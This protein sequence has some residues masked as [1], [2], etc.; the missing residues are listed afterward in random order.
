MYLVYAL[1]QNGMMYAAMWVVE[2]DFGD[3]KA[4]HLLHQQLKYTCIPVTSTVQNRNNIRSTSVWVNDPA[5]ADCRGLFYG[6]LVFIMQ[7]QRVQVCRRTWRNSHARRAPAPTERTQEDDIWYGSNQSWFDV[8]YRIAQLYMVSQC[9]DRVHLETTSLWIRIWIW[10]DEL[11]KHIM[12][13][14]YERGLY[15]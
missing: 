12:T 10:I 11:G 14:T 4:E 1:V 13:Q 3:G 5:D 2:P 9:F 6:L 8:N 7:P 15:E